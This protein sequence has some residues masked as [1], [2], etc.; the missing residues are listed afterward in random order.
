M[1]QC[2]IDKAG[3]TMPARRVDDLRPRR[4]VEVLPHRD[5]LA[6]VDENLSVFDVAA[7]IV[8]TKPP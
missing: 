7:V 3:V 4:N 2:C 6:A 5:D 1:W 8:L